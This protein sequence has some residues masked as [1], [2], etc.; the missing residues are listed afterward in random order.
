MKR[1]G[2]DF[3]ARQFLLTL[4]RAA[5][6]DIQN[7]FAARSGAASQQESSRMAGHRFEI[8]ECV[9]YLEK[10]FPNGVRRTELVVVERLA[11]IGEPQYRLRP[12]NGVALCVLA[13]SKLGPT[14]SAEEAGRRLDAS[15]P[16]P[17]GS[18]SPW[19]A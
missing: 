12:A 18:G 15:L 6:A 4:I 3:R 13:E 17:R 2:S 7:K 16:A 8:G 10:R 5:A 1:S 14:A 11:G 9:A 19:S